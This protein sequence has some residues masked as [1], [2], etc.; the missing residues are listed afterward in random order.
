ME[1][2]GRVTARIDEIRAMAASRTAPLGAFS[3]HLARAQHQTDPSG[4]ADDADTAE[5]SRGPAVALDLGAGSTYVRS[6]T[7]GSVLGLGSVTATVPFDPVDGVMTA[8]QLQMY[9]FEHQIEQR[10]GRLASTDLVPISGTWHGR[11]SLLPPAA[12]AWETMREAAAAD[13]IELTAIDTYR[14][15]ESQDRAHR[16]HLAGVK[17]ANVLPAGTSE[18][19]NGLAVD[20]TNGSIIDRADPEWRWLDANAARFGWHPISNEAWHW[21]FRGV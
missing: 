19:G 1:A 8:R 21:E 20:I 15:W 17:K 10:N 18:H 16:Q 7:L 3:A 9:L 4:P 13:G 12:A 2:I 6:A 14:T 5:Q 11:G